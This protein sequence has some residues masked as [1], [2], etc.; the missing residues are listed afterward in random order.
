MARINDLIPACQEQ[1]P[2]RSFAI[3]SVGREDSRPKLGVFVEI[4]PLFVGEMQN[5]NGF[6]FKRV[7][8][9]RVRDFAKRNFNKFYLERRLFAQD[10]TAQNRLNNTHLLAVTKRYFFVRDLLRQFSDQ[11]E[12]LRPAVSVNSGIPFDERH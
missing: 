3:R 10:P 6:V 12:T 2:A 7:R 9:G 5:Q 8:G 11:I 1:G 4:S